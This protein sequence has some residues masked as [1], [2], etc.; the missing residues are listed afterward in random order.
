MAS[1]LYILRKV[2]IFV[3]IRVGLCC[4]TGYPATVWGSSIHMKESKTM[5]KNVKKRYIAASVIAVAMA[6]AGVGAVV[7]DNV[8]FGADTPFGPANTVNQVPA[9][10]TA[11]TADT[12]TV[13]A[14]VTAE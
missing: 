3:C 6:A 2:Q 8:P 5:L 1:L 7:T 4:L 9:A 14:A 11:T 10:D 13:P 12:A